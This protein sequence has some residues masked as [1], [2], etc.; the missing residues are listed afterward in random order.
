MKNQ[1]Y[2]FL[3][4]NF[5][6]LSCK[7]DPPIEAPDQIFYWNLGNKTIFHRADT[8]LD[9]KSSIISPFKVIF[10]NTPSQDGKLN[11][12]LF[13]YGG[14]TLLFLQSDCKTSIKETIIINDKN[15]FSSVFMIDKRDKGYPVCTS[16]TSF[17]VPFKRIYKNNYKS[18]FGWIRVK[19]PI[20]GFWVIDD[21]AYNLGNHKSIFV[22]QKD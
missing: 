2:I 19:K 8:I 13:F 1:I 18:N 5:I 16:D 3:L 22:G 15:E 9:V 12:E 14:D 4:I 21:F 11:Y 17:F 7:N 20:E 10:K 6:F